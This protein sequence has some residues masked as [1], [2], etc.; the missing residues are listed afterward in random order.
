MQA[1]GIG[2]HHSWKPKPFTIYTPMTQMKYFWSTGGFLYI[3]FNHISSS[4]YKYLS[5]I[6]LKVT[7]LLQLFPS[8]FTLSI[9]CKAAGK[10]FFR[11]K[12]LRP[13]KKAQPWLNGSPWQTFAVFIMSILTGKIFVQSNFA[14]SPLNHVLF[15][16]YNFLI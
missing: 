3:N 14:L 13:G 2:K 1:S 5:A 7:F 11:R 4:L 16:L 12:I 6:V 15:V 10:L 8:F 9:C